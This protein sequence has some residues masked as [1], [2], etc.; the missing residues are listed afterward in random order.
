MSEPFAPGAAQMY[1]PLPIKYMDVSKHIWYYTTPP[2]SQRDSM[3][4]EMG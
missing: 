1:A 2:E 4:I 3:F